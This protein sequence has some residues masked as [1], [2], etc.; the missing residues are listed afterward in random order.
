[1]GE[2]QRFVVVKRLHEHALHDEGSEQRLLAEAQLAGF[3][4]HAN[5]VSMHQAGSDEEGDYLVCDY[6]EG[7]SLA[8]LI[9]HA[10]GRGKPPPAI[11]ARIL[12]DGLVGLHAAHEAVD[13]GGAPLGMLH[14]DVSMDNLLVGRD[15]V[16]RLSDFGIAKS[17]QT[18]VVTEQGM[19]QGKLIYF[20]PEYHVDQI[21]FRRILGTVNNAIY[22]K[23]QVAYWLGLTEARQL[24]VQA[25][26][27]Y[28][29]ANVTVSTPGNALSYGLELNIGATY[30]NPTDGFFAGATWGIL[31]PLAALDRPAEIWDTDADDADT[32]QVIRTFLGIV[33]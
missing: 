14:R 10:R 3:V 17:V 4:H 11:V 13:A 2:F 31:W 1:M 8:G 12:L 30:R 24:G 6:V 16:T 22:L 19:L 21:L 23:P 18:S 25:S 28:S 27:I 15:G 33:F 26:L 20:S 9:E 29:L 5:V 7:E 32:A